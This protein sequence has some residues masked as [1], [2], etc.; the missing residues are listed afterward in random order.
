VFGESSEIMRNLILFWFFFGLILNV[1]G[2]CKV[3]F[4][5]KKVCTRYQYNAGDCVPWNTVNCE[6]PRRTSHDFKCPVY[7]CDHVRNNETL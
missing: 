6:K 5:Y 2:Q 7:T 3:R 1:T 4:M